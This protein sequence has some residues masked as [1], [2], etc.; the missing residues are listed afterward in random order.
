MP[1]SRWFKVPPLLR[2]HQWAV[3]RGTVSV[4]EEGRGGGPQP[5]NPETPFCFDKL[6]DRPGIP[7]NSAQCCQYP[8]QGLAPRREALGPR[9]T[10]RLNE[11]VKPK[12]PECA[13]QDRQEGEPHS[14]A[15]F[16]TIR[17]QHSASGL[18]SE[19]PC[20]SSPRTGWP[21]PGSWPWTKLLVTRRWPACQGTVIRPGGGGFCP[22]TQ[23]SLEL[24]FCRKGLSGHGRS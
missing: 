16:K 11:P 1:G 14:G 4:G 9:T 12:Q 2:P 7:G 17:G 3:L 10:D 19:E 6:P 8:A 21:L 5:R 15:A 20:P 22:S 18:K 13:P 23:F 24:D